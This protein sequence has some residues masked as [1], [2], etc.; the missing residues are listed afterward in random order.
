M[1]A[2]IAFKAPRRTVRYLSYG[3]IAALILAPLAVFLPVDELY[4]QTGTMVPASWLHRIAIWQAAGSQIPAGLPFGFGADYARMWHETAPMVSV[5]GVA[6]P[7]STMPNHPHN[8]FLQVWLELGLPGVIALGGFLY[9]GG[10]T[11]SGAALQKPIIAAAAGAFSAIL[12]SLLVEGSLWQVWRF[13]AMGIAAMGVGLA[14][15]IHVNW[16]RLS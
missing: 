12:V 16:S 2:I 10:R 1:A 4:A 7:L 5:P 9:F 3:A 8:L 11:F 15:S 14:H 6:V 13:A